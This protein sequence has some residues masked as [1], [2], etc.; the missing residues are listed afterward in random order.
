MRITETSLK[1]IIREELKEILISERTMADIGGDLG[2]EADKLMI[3]GGSNEAKMIQLVKL[4]IDEITG[5]DPPCPDIGE[6]LASLLTNTLEAGDPRWMKASNRAVRSGSNKEMINTLIH[7]LRE[8]ALNPN[9]AEEVRTM[10]VDAGL[11][12]DNTKMASE[13]DEP[14]LSA[15]QSKSIYDS[16]QERFKDK[17]VADIEKEIADVKDAMEGLDPGDVDPAD[18]V[19]HKAL[20]ALLYY[21]TN[22]ES[23]EDGVVPPGYEMNKNWGKDPEG[24]S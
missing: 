18:K 23:G 10:F 12:D 4:A 1:R 20:M 16:V 11:Y 8:E 13:S 19:Q 15:N 14:A 9:E 24:I 3:T 5:D 7:F 6:C 2:S 21:Q 22:G 17:S